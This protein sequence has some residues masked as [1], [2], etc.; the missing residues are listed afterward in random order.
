MYTKVPTDKL[1]DIIDSLCEKHMINE[2]II[3][4]ITKVSKIIIR[5]NYFQF[6]N[7]F[8][9]QEKGLAMG[10]PTSSIF[11]E[12]FL[13]HI[14]STAIFDILVQ[15]HTVG[16]FRCVDDILIVYNKSITNIHDVFSSFNNPTPNIKF[17]MEKETESSIKF[18]DVMIRKEHDTF[19]F[20]VYRKPTT[21]DSI[22]PKDSCHPQKHKYTAI[23]HL[24]NR[25]NT[26]NLMQPIEKK[27]KH[28]QTH[29]KQEQI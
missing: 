20:N 10:S 9:I 16:Y 5:Q 13:K 21:T 22:I 4:E 7:S 12:I 26:H 29:T 19:T 3:H 2:K 6:L 24:V 17:T 28:H 8:F 23:R 18:L 1:V 15:N 11:S 14:E 27:K 25:M